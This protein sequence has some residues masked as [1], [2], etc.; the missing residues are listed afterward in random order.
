MIE[1]RLEC[2]NVKCERMAKH[3]AKLKRLCEY[4]IWEYND[5]V[6]VFLK[7]R[8]VFF[9]KELIRKL[10]QNRIEFRLA[11]VKHTLPWW[12]KWKMD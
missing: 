3:I 5:I 4:T 6:Y 1:V 2:R 11:K 9:L 8:S 12:R 10:K 7:F